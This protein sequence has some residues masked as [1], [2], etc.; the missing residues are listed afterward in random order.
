MS[1][2]NNLTIY[3]NEKNYVL[4]VLTERET[5]GCVSTEYKQTYYLKYSIDIHQIINETKQAFVSNDKLKMQTISLFTQDCFGRREVVR[6]CR[7]IYRNFEGVYTYLAEW[8]KYKQI[9]DIDNPIKTMA[10]KKETVETSLVCALGLL[11]AGITE[12]LNLTN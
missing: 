1:K 8:S 11:S 12:C 4:E 5:N 2:F 10:S 7:I 6:S 3:D 9:Y